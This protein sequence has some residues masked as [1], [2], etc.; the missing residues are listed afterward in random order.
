MK[1]CSLTNKT[2]YCFGTVVS[3]YIVFGTVV[4]LYIVFVNFKYAY[5]NALVNPRGRHGREPG[6]ANCYFHT[7]FGKK[8]CKIIG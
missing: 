8:I 3:L 4:S 2:S 6:G 1:S 5:F 7:V